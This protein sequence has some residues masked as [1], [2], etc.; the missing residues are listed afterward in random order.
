[1]AWTKIAD[2][3][4]GI[5]YGSDGHKRWQ[6]VGALLQDSNNDNS[7]GPGFTIALN[8]TFNPAGA[9]IFE[10]N[11]MLSCYHPMKNGTPQ[12]QQRATARHVEHSPIDGDDIP[13]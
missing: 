10:G 3:A 11:V 2:I 4:V 8:S 7:K 9:P 6:N 1:M 12:H 13:F 5:P